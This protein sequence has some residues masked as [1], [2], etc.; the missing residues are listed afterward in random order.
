MTLFE[1]AALSLVIAAQVGLGWVAAQ[2]H[3][4]LYYPTVAI[5]MSL[6]V[7]VMFRPNRGENKDSL[8]TAIIPSA[9][10]LTA[11]LATAFAVRYASRL[12]TGA[13]VVALLAAPVLNV[14][15]FGM[16][17]AILG[18]VRRNGPS[19]RPDA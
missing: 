13:V 5:L 19:D 15:V 10:L 11:A 16:V 12:D 6:V 17:S 9:M 18:P 7:W 14:T 8:T 1:L 4:A 3:P 2:A